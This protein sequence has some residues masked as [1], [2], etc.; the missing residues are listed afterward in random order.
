MWT[1]LLNFWRVKRDC[2]GGLQEIEN[3]VNGTKNE[4]C[5][6]ASGISICPRTSNEAM[7]TAL[8]TGFAR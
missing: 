8:S 1:S 4:I 6:A 3:G 7:I 5:T 2:D